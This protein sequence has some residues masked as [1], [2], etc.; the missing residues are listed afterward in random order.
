[1]VGA[2]PMIDAW[3]N[4]NFPTSV[5]DATVAKLFA[6]LEQRRRRGPR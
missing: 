4:P 6:G 2:F 5:V 1:M 3:V